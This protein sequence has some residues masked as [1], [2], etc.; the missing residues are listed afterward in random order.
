MADAVSTRSSSKLLLVVLTGV[1]MLTCGALAYVV[2]R[3]S[4]SESGA[5]GASPSTGTVQFP[6][7]T[8][9]GSDGSGS[10]V[11]GNSTPAV[12]TPPGTVGAHVQPRAAGPAGGD[13]GIQQHGCGNRPGDALDGG[14][15]A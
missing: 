14:H 2:V 7:N 1:L 5:A 3:D 6:Q 15:G 13:A 9:A 4:P 10:T 11:P 12:T 8:T